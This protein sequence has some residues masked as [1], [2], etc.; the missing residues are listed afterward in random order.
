MGVAFQEDALGRN[1]ARVGA[2]H[3]PGPGDVAADIL[4]GHQKI[5]GVDPAVVL[6]DEVDD[7][8][9]WAG[10]AHPGDLRQR[11]AGTRLQLVVL[12]AG[13]QDIFGSP[14]AMPKVLPAAGGRA[15][16]CVHPPPHFRVSGLVPR[17]LATSA[18]VLPV[19][20]FSLSFLKPVSRTFSGP[21]A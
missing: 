17:I 8:V 4:F 14:G 6:D 16:F 13:P 12:E 21:P 3:R 15:P 2:D 9:L 11:L 20:G 19:S 5:N 1:T 7:R 18:S 10:A